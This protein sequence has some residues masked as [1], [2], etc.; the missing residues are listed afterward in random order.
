MF[1]TVE[2]GVRCPHQQICTRCSD[3][4]GYLDQIEFIDKI[5]PICKYYDNGCQLEDPLECER[6]QQS[7]CPYQC[8]LSECP[9]IEEFL[10]RQ[11]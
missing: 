6:Q 10:Q 5:C 2:K 11:I 9:T 7:L 1:G 3:E 8:D 4:H